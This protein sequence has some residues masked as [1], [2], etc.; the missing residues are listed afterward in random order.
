MIVIERQF[1]NG[2]AKEYN[3]F[4][5][6]EADEKGIEYVYWTD[7]D[8][9]EWGLT[10]DGYVQE[11]HK[12]YEMNSGPD[13]YALQFKYTV[14]RPIVKFKRG[15]GKIADKSAFSFMKFAEKGAYWT[16]SPQT[17]AEREAKRSRMHRAAWIWA[18]LFLIRRGDL[19]QKDWRRIGESWRDGEEIPA[20][21]ARVLFKQPEILKMATKKLV[22][23]MSDAGVEQE[24]VVEMYTEFIDQNKDS[25]KHASQV[26]EALRD[27]RDMAGLN[28]RMPKSKKSGADLEGMMNELQAAENDVDE[29]EVSDAKSLPS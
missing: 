8:E 27:L 12:I 24:D 3:V 22:E 18:Q 7:V 26:L 28:P 6:E 14:G 23:V 4:P 9:G 2:P 10:D 17:W 29:I 11:C 15:T 20:A 19:S 1:N 13:E 21:S 16:S 5:Q 25:N